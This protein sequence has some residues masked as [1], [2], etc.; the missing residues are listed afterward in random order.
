MASPTHHRLQWP[1]PGTRTCAPV[2][3]P[4]CSAGTAVTAQ[5]RPRWMQPAW[6][7]AGVCQREQARVIT[8][9]VNWVNCSCGEKTIKFV[10]FHFN[11]TLEKRGVVGGG[12][13]VPGTPQAGDRAPAHTQRHCTPHNIMFNEMEFRQLAAHLL[14]RLGCLSKGLQEGAGAVAGAAAGVLGGQPQLPLHPVQGGRGGG[15]GGS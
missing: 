14:Q 8:C 3:R 6:H 7:S 13:G 5:Y 15:G 4:E 11:E 1:T 10:C 12:G 2:Y 9:G